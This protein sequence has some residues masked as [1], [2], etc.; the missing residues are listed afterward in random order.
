MLSARTILCTRMIC[1]LLWVA[2]MAPASMPRGQTATGEI[3]GT[4]TDKSG[5][6]ISEAAVKLTN[7]TT[8]IVNQTVTN[9]SGNF[10]FINVQPGSY[11]LTVEKEGFKTDQVSSFEVSVNQTI[12]QTVIL[13]VGATTETITVTAEGEMIERSTSE[14]GTVISEKAIEALPLN[15]RNFTQLLTLVPGVT[16]VS[17]SQNKSIGGV[18][19]NVG[20]PGSGFS[21]PSFHG[22]QNR[23]KLYF[24]DGII[25]TNVRGPTYIV[26]PNNDLVQEFKVVGHDAKAEFGGATGGVVNMV[27]KVGGNGLH[28]SAFEYVRND[29]FDAR[30]TFTDFDP[31]A[32]SPRIFP[33]RQN[34]FGVAVTGPIIKNRTFFSAGYD[35]WRYSKPPLTL[36]YV[37][38]P[39]ELAGDFSQT[40]A[41]ANTNIFN[42][43]S[44]TGTTTFTREPFRCDASG[45]P[46]HADP[47]THLQPNSPG[48]VACNKIPNYTDGTGLINPAM[49]KF[50]QTYSP[51][52]N[53]PGN[54][55][56]NYQQIRPDT[57]TSNSFQ[58]RV[59]HRFR[60][61]DEVF[62]RYTEQRVATFTPIGDVGFT[63]G[64][65]AGRNYG[66][67]WV[68]IFKP[69]LILEV[70]AGYA[71][72]PGVDSGQQN[73]STLG[74]GPMKDA[75]FKDIDKYGGMLVNLNNDWTAGANSNFGTRGP[76]LRENPNWSV[77]PNLNWLKGNHN[78]KTGFW[79]IDAKR[80]QLNTFQTFNFRR[81][82]TAFP[83]DPR[84][85]LTLASA[86][87]A[88]PN[89]F[90][91]QLPI[92]HGGPVRYKYA[93]WAAYI[94]DE[95]KV[96]R[97]LTLSLGLR[98]D[99]L[100]QPQVTDGR[101]WSSIDLTKKQYVIGSLAM[102]PLCSVTKQAP[103]IPDGGPLYTTKNSTC[104]DK[105]NGIPCDFTR[106]P[107]FSSVV[108][109][110]KHFFDPQPIRDNWGPR[111]GV[112]WQLTPKTVLRAGYGL[113][114]DALAGRGQASQNDLEHGI[115]PDATAFNGDINAPTDFTGAK[116]SKFITDIQGNFPT[117]L[118]SVTP[119]TVGGFALDPHTYK[120]GYSNQWN[121]E[122]QREITPS[123]LVAAAYVGSRN[124][125]LSYEGKANSANRASVNPCV[126]VADTP[127]CRAD[128]KIAVDAFRVMPWVNPGFTYAQ[129][130]GYSNYNALESKIQRRFTNGLYSLLSYTWGKS[131]DVS[132]GYFGVENG[133]G[134]GSAVQNYYD[135]STA[136]GVSGYD[137]THFLSWATVYELPAGHGKKWF[138]SG[139]ASWLL[140]NWE[141]SYIFQARSGQPYTLR[142]TGDPANLAGSGG[143]NAQPFTNYAR[144]NI[145]ADPFQAG[146]V[147][148]N[149]TKVGAKDCTKTISN[150]G[151]AADQVHTPTTWFNPCAFA[152]PVGAFGNFGR[153]AL[154]GPA[155]YNMDVSLFKKFPLPREG[156]ELELQFQSFNIFNIQNWDTP[157]TQNIDAGLTV[158]N[159]AFGQIRTLAHDPR[160]MQLGLRFVF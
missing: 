88:L 30:N 22:Q 80:V 69:N 158:A 58:F 75:G 54:R 124:G 122:I 32:K 135:Q 112:A 6:A 16:P 105:P 34:Q 138:Q 132:S 147:P 106:D 11:I 129:S 131:I 145:V 139:P 128:F 24:Y 83:D 97:K 67:G 92:L 59:D 142:V 44:T 100:T 41:V 3:N 103:C 90:N 120:D 159:S 115:W 134:G 55:S 19:G 51:K 102:P 81:S 152:A 118:P 93:S 53:L 127:A 89:D 70:R 45:N 5:A 85:G 153:N 113:Y 119:W 155:V 2:F 160:Q 108:L 35:G 61:N 125:R 13:S 74:T 114:W 144:P 12:S 18:E 150:G 87:L 20:I 143:V 26:I 60:D 77:T 28:G 23:S 101:L 42:P 91:A 40:T 84:S 62:F 65:S 7:H 9:S 63:S 156:W 56:F 133:N 149:P 86:L 43:F 33:F 46:L 71:G 50:L 36:T 104:N 126:G 140:G 38:T 14:L 78:F 27:S 57:N 82:Q 157:T 15:G 21:D 1:A 73:Q 136:R 111:V 25:N 154:R 39:A 8:K 98:F 48:S 151:L 121:I 4:V 94:Q 141:L 66:G 123:M 37:P 64:S 17:S 31:I 148:G 117:P 29:A 146:P 107:H 137:I 79:F 116:T 52:P 49:Q 110:G 109:A 10:L 95:W 96:S 130:I 72:R 47:I 76:A 68:H 99:A